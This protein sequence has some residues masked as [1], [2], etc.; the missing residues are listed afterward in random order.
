MEKITPITEEL[1]QLGSGLGNFP[2][3]NPY[4][5]P[6]GYFD[7]FPARMFSLASGGSLPAALT[8]LPTPY[9]VPGGYFDNLP[10]TILK[11]ALASSSGNQSSL[12]EQQATGQSNSGQSTSQ[13]SGSKRSASEQL[14]S[15]QSASEPAALE[16]TALEATALESA[17]SESAASKQSASESATL[18]ESAADEL[19]GLSSI[20]SGIGKKT[21]FTVPPDYFDELSGNIISGAQAVELVNEEL[22]NLSPL[23]A[24]L[25]P[26]N[27]YSVPNEY[28]RELPGIILN[29]VKVSEP[30]GT[31][32]VNGMFRRRIMQYAA[33]AVITGLMITAGFFFADRNTRQHEIVSIKGLQEKAAQ[34]SDEEILNYLAT[35][36]MPL[37]D[38]L[39]NADPEIN[40]DA[41]LDMLANVSDE[42]LQQ[43]LQLQTDS[44]I[45]IN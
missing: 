30:A 37:V 4:K 19:A 41:I 27:V 32:V 45:L 5:V 17:A 36:Q 11:K 35:Q 8:G 10:E 40:A 29:K 2:A 33:A 44:K 15:E 18:E 25:K 12:A 1:K 14:A 28:F 22:E 7:E 26:V 3:V 9:Q 20:L 16:A 39:M 6:A 43:Y 38:S 21:P 42:E 24:S 13:P 31:R 34:T 23:M